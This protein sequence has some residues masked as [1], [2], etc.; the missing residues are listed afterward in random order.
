[1]NAQELHE[2][3]REIV[4]QCVRL[5][6]YSTDVYINAEDC[7]D[8]L[9]AL[10]AAYAAAQSPQ[11]AFYAFIRTH[12]VEYSALMQSQGAGTQRAII[13]TMINSLVKYAETLDKEAGK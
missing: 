3:R 6:A 1:M 12:D 13:D 8:E 7:L 10:D 2:A 4:T 5:H 9:E 11:D